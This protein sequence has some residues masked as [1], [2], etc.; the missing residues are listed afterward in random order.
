MALMVSCPHDDVHLRRL[1]YG[2]LPRIEMHLLSLD[3]ASRNSRFGCGFG[4][5]AVTAYVRGLD[6][7]RDILFGATQFGTGQIVGLA[8]VRPAK[9]FQ[10]VDLGVSVLASHRKCGLAHELVALAVGAAFDR[11][12]K[13]I[14]LTF[15]PSNMA[16]RHIA[17]KL[18]ANFLAP[19]FAVVHERGY[20][21][22]QI[23]GTV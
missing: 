21:D 14:E 8:E 15:V 13:A 9:A 20:M 23:N 11:G 1:G 10:A 3:M 22:N 6:L 18:E 2:D 12:A 7:A 16:A 5:W 4:N 17:A 19:G